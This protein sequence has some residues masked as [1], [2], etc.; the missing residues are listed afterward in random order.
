[1][2]IL[3]WKLFE[4]Y[5]Q[6]VANVIYDGE[7]MQ[8]FT[9]RD[10]FSVQV[11]QM[12]SHHKRLV[13]I[14]NAIIEQG[15]GRA[16]RDALAK[17]FDALVDY[18]RY[19]FAAEE[20]LMLLYDY[21]GSAGHVKKHE[22]L[23]LQVAEYRGRVLAGDVPDKASFLH[24]FETWMIRHILDEDRKYGAFLNEKGVY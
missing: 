11:A 7:R 1:V 5:Q 6:R 15:Q 18:T 4:N 20:K 8:V 23:T 24:F 12:D 16:D 3:R 21:P 9:W 2:P 10:A 19:H 13:E 14:A 17:A 22:M